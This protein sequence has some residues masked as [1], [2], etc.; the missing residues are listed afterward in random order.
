[1]TLTL[2]H[3]RELVS[4]I[5][6]ALTLGAD[7]D[8]AAL[9]RGVTTADFLSCGNEGDCADREAVAKRFTLLPDIIPDLSWQIADLWVAND[10]TVVVRGRASGTPVKPFLGQ[11]PTGR[12]FHTMSIDLYLT[13]GGLIARSYHVENWMAALAQLKTE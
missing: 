11:A 1:M 12:A 2:E 5:Y 13:R 10:D 8:I 4:P 7:K 9:I 6:D 3:A